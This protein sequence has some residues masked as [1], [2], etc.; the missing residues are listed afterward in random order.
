[1]PFNFDQA[2]TQAMQENRD[3]IEASREKQQQHQQANAQK[4]KKAVEQL[5]AT[6]FQ[7]I[8]T[9]SKKG[10]HFQT[11]HNPQMVQLQ[12]FDT[13]FT[14]KS[15]VLECQTRN[16]VAIAFSFC[17]QTPVSPIIEEQCHEEADGVIAFTDQNNVSLVFQLF[18]DEQSALFR[19]ARYNLIDEDFEEIDEGMLAKTLIYLLTK[20]NL[21]KYDDLAV[22][23]RS[24]RM[25]PSRGA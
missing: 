6:T 23:G 13:T 22:T 25:K 4:F 7:R 14:V 3:N 10:L 18:Y 5:I 15:P 12:A 2:F 24:R 21:D 8:V 17:D 19:I 1:M 11:R 9:W 16:T 20:L